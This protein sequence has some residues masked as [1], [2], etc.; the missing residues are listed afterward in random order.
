MVQK[1]NS[2]AADDGVQSV[3][4]SQH[5]GA[6]ELLRNQ[7]LHGLLCHNIDVG[8]SLVQDNKLVAL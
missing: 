8:S 4:D 6:L 2:V 7:F 3:S 5:G 1:E